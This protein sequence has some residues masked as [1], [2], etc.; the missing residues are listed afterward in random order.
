[1]FAVG[2]RGEPAEREQQRPHRRPLRQQVA[3][4]TLFQ[5]SQNL[6]IIKVFKVGS[7][8]SQKQNI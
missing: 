8:T 4:I 3:A 6:K 2:Q 7:G 5:G 1:M